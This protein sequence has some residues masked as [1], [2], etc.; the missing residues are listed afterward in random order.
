MGQKDL[1]LDWSPLKHH[2]LGEYILLELF[3]KHLKEANLS[4][5]W[6]LT[7]YPWKPKW[8]EDYLSWTCHWNPT[9]IPSTFMEIPF[10][11]FSW[12]CLWN[13]F[14]LV[15]FNANSILGDYQHILPNQ[16]EPVALGHP[17]RIPL[18][19]GTCFHPKWQNKK[20]AQPRS[21][22]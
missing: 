15:F 9:E 16:S 2:P 22:D 1:T 12:K 17:I 5:I 14:E 6:D 3:P 8:L 20:H 19:Q 7:A 13:P 11:D 18:D 21:Y 4:K 10:N